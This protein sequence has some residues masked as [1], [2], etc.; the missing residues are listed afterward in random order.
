MWPAVEIAAHYSEKPRRECRS[1]RMA[2]SVCLLSPSA[3]CT[4]PGWGPAQGMALLT[5]GGASQSLRSS[6][7]HKVLL[8]SFLLTANK[9][10]QGGACFT[11]LWNS[12]GMS[13]QLVS[14]ECTW[15]TLCV[16]MYAFKQIFSYYLLFFCLFF[17]RQSHVTQAKGDLKLLILL[18]LLKLQA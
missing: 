1:Q 3:P 17:L 10:R 5:V 11:H 2:V 12:H 16:C 14:F 7:S 9:S 6:S 13:P 4:A 8:H 15:S 18:P